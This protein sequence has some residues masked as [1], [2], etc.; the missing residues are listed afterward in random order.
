VVPVFLCIDLEP[1]ERLARLAD[2]DRWRGV[3]AVVDYLERLR[4]RLADASGEDPRFL[5]FVRCDPQIETAFGSASDL[6][7]LRSELLGRLAEKGDRLGVHVHAWRWR[8][9]AGDWIA[10]FGDQAWVGHCVSSSFETYHAHFGVPAELHRFGDRFL[11]TDAVRR[12]AELGARFDLTIE[13]GSPGDMFGRGERSSGSTPDFA[14]APRDPYR[15]SAG[16]FL[17]PDPTAE[18]TLVLVPLS[19]ADPSAAL[20][21]GRRIARKVRYPLRPS[22]RP[23]T[24]YRTWSSPQAYWDLVERHV[25]SRE[26]PYLAFAIRSGEPGGVD[27]RQARAVLDH[28]PQHPLAR[29]LRFTGPASCLRELG[30]AF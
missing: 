29:R 19:S 8:E 5:W 30:F 6:L 18:S 16:D 23:L 1:P 13:P 11:S 26:R 22:H 21:I 4:P 17:V 14:R 9:D 27:D 25:D 24:L 15:P 3:D 10:D 12:L 7:D 28:L 2:P 20:P